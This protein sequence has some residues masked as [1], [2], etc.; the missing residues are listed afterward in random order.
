MVTSADMSNNNTTNEMKEDVEAVSVGERRQDI[1]KCFDEDQAK[2][3]DEQ[4]ES[5]VQELRKKKLVRTRSETINE[6]FERDTMNAGE[7]CAGVG[8]GKGGLDVEGG[9]ELISLKERTQN[10]MRNFN[11]DMEKKYREEPLVISTEIGNL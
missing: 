9:E 1:L 8:E 6:Q 2:Q 4:V 3:G 10:L 11:Q 5:S 7:G